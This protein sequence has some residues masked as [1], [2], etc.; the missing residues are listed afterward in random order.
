M[1]GSDFE[2]SEPA[3][4]ARIR[5]R[6][7]RIGAPRIAGAEQLPPISGALYRLLLSKE[8]KPMHIRV[9]VFVGNLLCKPC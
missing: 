9:I 5:R 8:P 4:E 6:A 2:K 7:L 1:R 3:Q